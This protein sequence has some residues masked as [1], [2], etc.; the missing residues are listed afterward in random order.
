MDVGQS[1]NIIFYFFILTFTLLPFGPW[2]SQKF[3]LDWPYRAGACPPSSTAQLL[4][5]VPSFISI[6]SSFT[7]Y[8]LF[9]KI[10]VKFWTNGSRLAALWVGPVSKLR[11]R[12]GEPRASKHLPHSFSRN[13]F[14]GSQKALR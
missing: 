14:P 3:F 13:M 12:T 2:F 5:F 8:F 9:L 4:S 1:R 6:F 11:V 7:L 10:F